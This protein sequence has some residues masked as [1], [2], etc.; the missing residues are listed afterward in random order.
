MSDWLDKGAL[1]FAEVLA[2]KY[3]GRRFTVEVKRDRGNAVSD[4]TARRGELQAVA[5][6]NNLNPLT[7]RDC[8]TAA[9]SSHGDIVQEAA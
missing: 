9:N 2:A 7:D 3:P 8:D 1:A 5:G 6:S 4:L